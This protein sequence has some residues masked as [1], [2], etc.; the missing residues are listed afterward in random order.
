MQAD[1]ESAAL[2]RPDHPVDFVP[3]QEPSFSFVPYHV[4]QQQAEER[5]LAE[6][7]AKA[8]AKKAA[9]ARRSSR[10]NKR[11]SDRATPANKRV[12]HRRTNSDSSLSSIMT[13]TTK[14][15][16]AQSEFM[17]YSDDLGEG[18]IE[19]GLYADLM[20]EVDTSSPLDE[21]LQVG[22]TLESGDYLGLDA[23]IDEIM[24]DANSEHLSSD[25]VSADTLSE[26]SNVEA[27]RVKT[28]PFSQAETLPCD[29]GHIDMEMPQAVSDV[30]MLDLKDFGLG[31]DTL[32]DEDFIL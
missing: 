13:A 16:A 17:D 10:R 26:L 3:G 15:E 25:T 31:S 18:L 4:A 20:D 1:F 8:K 5:A 6:V 12:K 29:L 21:D 11:S 27:V 9:E 7:K 30:D 24:G 32:L 14:P 23:G 2:A 22:R 19:L 28:E